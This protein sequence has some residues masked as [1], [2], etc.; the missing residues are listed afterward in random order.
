MVTIKT[1]AEKCGLSIAAVSKALNGRPGISPERAEFVRKTAQEMGY[2]ANSA[3]QMLKT[4]RSHNIGILYENR[5]AHEFFSIVLEA[6][7]DELESNGYD[8]T[9]LSNQIWNDSGVYEHAKYRKCDGVIIVQAGWDRDGVQRL[10]DGDIPVISIDRIYHGRTTVA[11]DNV[12]SLE[13]IIHYLHKMGHR[14]IA[15]IHGED[16][17]VTRQR[18]A[19]FYRGCRDCGIE[20]PDEYVIP[21]RYHEP[22]DSGQAVQR[23]MALKTPPT[24]IL[25][26]DDT[27]YLG[28]QTALEKM[29]LSVPEDVSC[30]GYDG[31]R[32]AGVLRPRL[33]TY[34]QNAPGIG[35]RAAEEL[36]SAIELPK[37]YVPQIVT[38]TGSIQEGSTVKDLTAGSR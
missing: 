2:C 6:I 27:C 31:I 14:R 38:V 3:A 15:F 17:D 9:L 34:Q 8:I 24:C 22:K 37:F 33:S 23:L 1:I 35:K 32:L 12:G 18:L 21:A 16:D 25:F 36:I 28:G 7:R 26:P 10:V 29:G 5:L 11:S 4:N 20:V 19:G 13:K 30:F